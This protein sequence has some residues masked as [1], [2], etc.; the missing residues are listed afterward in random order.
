VR[1]NSST[2]LF[3]L[4]SWQSWSLEYVARLYRSIAPTSSAYYT[5]DWW[6]KN[7]FYYRLL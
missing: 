2:G 3:Y 5:V 6:S 4:T 7:S 1:A